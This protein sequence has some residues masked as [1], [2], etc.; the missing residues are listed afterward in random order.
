MQAEDFE[1]LFI[2]EYLV[3]LNRTKAYARAK[4]IKLDGNATTS[5]RGSA[6]RLYNKLEPEIRI[7]M[8]ERGIRT[9]VTADR[10]LREIAQ[11]A[12]V[13]LDDIVSEKRPVGVSP[14]FTVGNKL[15]ALEKL[16]KHHG[17]YKKDNEQKPTALD[18]LEMTNEEIMDE[19]RK[20]SRIPE[21]T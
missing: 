8:E 19:I 6:H 13:P 17:L 9:K 11:I 18:P 4:G 12:F 3:D 2:Q 21:R 1:K 7:A 16:M 20:R 5:I 14:K 15:E 10:V